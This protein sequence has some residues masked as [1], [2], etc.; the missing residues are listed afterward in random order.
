MAR[1]LTRDEVAAQINAWKKRPLGTGPMILE[2]VW[3]FKAGFI[4]GLEFQDAEL[5]RLRAENK[6][7]LEAARVAG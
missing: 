4:A 1:E 5:A 2:K 6:R 3:A 7:L